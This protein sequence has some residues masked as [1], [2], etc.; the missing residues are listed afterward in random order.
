[1]SNEFVKV[2]CELKPSL[3]HDKLQKNSDRSIAQIICGIFLSQR[4]D[5]KTKYSVMNFS[6]CLVSGVLCTHHFEIWGKLTIGSPNLVKF[7]EME[8]ILIHK[9]NQAFVF[10][11][12][13]NENLNGNYAILSFL[14][15]LGTK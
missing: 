11:H 8:W 14:L 2:R 1:M 9:D 6:S 13:D 10:R 7:K 5:M 15:M 4:T 12:H 3:M